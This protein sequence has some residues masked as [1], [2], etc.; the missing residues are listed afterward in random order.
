MN[1]GDIMETK[2]DFDTEVMQAETDEG[3]EADLSA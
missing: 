3:G 1:K 2:R